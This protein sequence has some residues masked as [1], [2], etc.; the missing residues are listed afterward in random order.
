MRHITNFKKA[1]LD[2]NIV[3]AQRLIPD[4]R[5]E[6]RALLLSTIDSEENTPLHLACKSCNKELVE[7]LVRQMKKYEVSF[8]TKNKKGFQ[9]LHSAVVGGKYKI[10]NFLVE[11]GGVDINELTHNNCTALHVACDYGKIEIAKH[12]IEEKDMQIDSIGVDGR[13]PLHIASSNNSKNANEIASYLITKG[14]DVNLVDDLGHNA[15][16][17]FAINGNSID[18]FRKIFEKITNP[19]AADAD[20]NTALHLFCNQAYNDTYEYHSLNFRIATQYDSSGSRTKNNHI[21]KE[22]IESMDGITEL[23]IPNILGNT[24][25]HLLATQSTR[26]LLFELLLDRCDNINHQNI[27]GNTVFHIACAAKYHHSCTDNIIL[28]LLEHKADPSITNLD[29]K[30]AKNIAAKHLKMAE[31]LDFHDNMTYLA[32][33]L[34]LVS[35]DSIISH[36]NFGVIPDAVHYLHSISNDSMCNFEN[37]PV[38]SSSTTASSSDPIAST[39]SSSFTSIVDLLG[40]ISSS[41]IPYKS[42]APIRHLTN[43]YTSPDISLPLRYKPFIYSPYKSTAPTKVLPPADNSPSISLPALYDPSTSSNQRRKRIMELDHNSIG[44][45]DSNKNQRNIY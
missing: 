23:N 44:N 10:V 16:H 38:P 37:A 20:G 11:E 39:S 32:R 33:D 12:L 36:E 43:A 40:D 21:V 26:K 41:Y 35:N 15:L 31:S 19:M 17:I 22:F 29:G 14:A 24:P 18:L 6:A 7:F 2:G 13:T 25:M 28:K 9:A 1:I 3:S 34:H 27:D 4:N 8:N 30:S 45:Y 42:T 5:E